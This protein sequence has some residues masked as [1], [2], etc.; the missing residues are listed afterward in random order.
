M[1]RLR[2]VRPEAAPRADA[3][4]ALALVA[5]DP[6]AEAL[7]VDLEAT[8]FSAS[9]GVSGARDRADRVGLDPATPAVLPLPDAIVDA[10][11]EATALILLT[12]VGLRRPDDG[13][14]PAGA[15][16]ADAE[17]AFSLSAAAAST[18]DMLR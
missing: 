14:T 3:M 15:P 16:V 17:A 10:F 9:R 2:G 5:V 8:P 6:R 18:D 1:A 11:L 12:G 7:P 13:L 4:P